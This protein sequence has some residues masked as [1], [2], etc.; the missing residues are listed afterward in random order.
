M[1]LCYL[2]FSVCIVLELNLLQLL[3][4]SKE[5]L[6]FTCEHSS[7]Y[8]IDTKLPLKQ[9]Q[10][11]FMITIHLINIINNPKF[12]NEMNH[13]LLMPGLIAW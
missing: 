1:H 11:H 9:W 5:F 4:K 7:R 3:V 12:Y 6:E 8:I 13:N 2:M 10:R